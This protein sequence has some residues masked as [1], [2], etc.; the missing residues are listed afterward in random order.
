[1]GRA[2]FNPQNLANQKVAIT[3]LNQ[4]EPTIAYPPLVLIPLFAGSQNQQDCIAKES[5]SVSCWFWG[6]ASQY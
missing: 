2:N 1:M 4:R 6:S 3:R 5:D